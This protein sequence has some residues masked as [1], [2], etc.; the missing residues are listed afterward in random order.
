M[1]RDK[2][3]GVARAMPSELPDTVTVRYL[4]GASRCALE[5]ARA[6]LSAFLK[7]RDVAALTEALRHLRDSLRMRQAAARVE[8]A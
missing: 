1:H 6:D 2:S 5:S 4:R 8:A 3:P 7:C